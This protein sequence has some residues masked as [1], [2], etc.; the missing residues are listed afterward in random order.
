MDKLANLIDVS[1]LQQLAGVGEA[2]K[3][4]RGLFIAMVF[5]VLVIY[6]LSVGRTKALVS[7]L[8]IF[9]AYTLTVLFPFLDALAL[10][11]NGQVRPVSAVLLFLAFY[12][13]VFLLLSHSSMKHRMTLGEISIFQVVL[14]SAVQIGLLASIT[15]SLVPPQLAGRAFGSLL[16]FIAG[17][18]TLWLWAAASVAILPFLR[19]RQSPY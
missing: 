8:S 16:P 1:R 6:G 18:R 14:I 19:T 11:L 15:T 7:L 12:V 5:I 4:P 3:E 2:L 9:V 17:Q 13:L 10:R